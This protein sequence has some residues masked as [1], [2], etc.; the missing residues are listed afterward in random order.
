MGLQ[1][2]VVREVCLNLL[3]WDRG[4]QKR[5][6]AARGTAEAPKRALGR[7]LRGAEA[8]FALTA[9][10]K[11]RARSST[12]TPACAVATASCRSAWA[13]HIVPAAPTAG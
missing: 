7:L 9:H 2:K 1:M 4:L 11:P 8:G 3:G 13:R 6:V 5:F 10:T 12:G